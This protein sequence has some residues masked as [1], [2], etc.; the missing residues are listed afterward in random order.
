MRYFSTLS[1]GA[2]ALALAACNASKR[3]VTTKSDQG[4]TSSPTGQA[5]ADRDMSLVRVVNASGEANV[6]LLADEKALFDAVAPEQVTPYKEIKEN[7]VTFAV[8]GA[9]GAPTTGEQAKNR[10]AL[11]DGQ[12]YTAVVLPAAKGAVPEL[13][14]LH[15]ELTP[16]DGKAR[17]RVINAAVGEGE[18]DVTLHAPTQGDHPHDQAGAA[19]R[20]DSGK[21]AGTTRAKANESTRDATNNDLFDNLN[22]GSEGGFKDIDPT[23]GS[24]E[25]RRDGATRALAS[26]TNVRFEPGTAYTFVVMKDKGGKVD[27]VKFEDKVGPKTQDVG[28]NR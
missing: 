10:E 17:I 16:G 23:T 9:P 7:M 24:L 19:A 11:V 13:R 28:V 8:Q 27:V 21:T 12:R 20:A 22:Y 18:I 25:I 15:D 5:A 14:V 6:T 26:V 4:T 2:A 3:P 1:F